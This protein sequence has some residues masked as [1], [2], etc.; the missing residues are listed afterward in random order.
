MARECEICGRGYLKGNTRSHS[1]I[2]T[3]NRQK[4]NL[5]NMKKDGKKVNACTKCIK[6][7][8]KNK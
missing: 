3:I 8:A 6:T 5:Q 4:I 1:N 2:A 7:E